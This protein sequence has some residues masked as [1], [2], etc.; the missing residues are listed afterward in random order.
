VRTLLV[1]LLLVAGLWL[2]ATHLQSRFF[3][4]AIPVCATMVGLT[5]A[6]RRAWIVPGIATL[7]VAFPGY[8]E[9]SRQLQMYPR[10]FGVTDFK[11]AMPPAYV[12]LADEG[13]NVALV[14]EAQAFWY[15]LPMSRLSY[16]TVF[17]VKAGGS[18]DSITP[19]LGPDPRP[20]Q[21][22]LVYPNELSRFAKT[23]KGI[24]APSPDM[25]SQPEP[26]VMPPRGR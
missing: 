23:Y 9:L 20:D 2:F 21:W 15:Q 10:I 8:L 22:M 13:R 7:L 6:W 18:S 19:W 12:K 3:V 24:P 14:G 1:L 5:P 16:R 25:S 17:D 11:D 26:I 4:L